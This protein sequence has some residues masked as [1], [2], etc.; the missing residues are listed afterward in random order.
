MK[1]LIII[2]LI[3]LYIPVSILVA[4]ED[5]V[6]CLY[7][8]EGIE[9]GEL[10]IDWGFSALVYYNDLL[11]LFDAGASAEILEHN[12][13]ILGVNLDAVDIAVLSHNHRDHITGFNY[14]L[15]VN[16]DVKIYLP[17]DRDLGGESSI[18]EEEWNSK[19]RVGYRFK[20]AD[21]TFVKQN[22]LIAPGVAL[23]PTVASSIGVYLKDPKDEQKTRYWGLPE[24]SLAIKSDDDKWILIDG[25]SH[26]GVAEIVNVCVLRSYLLNTFVF[27]V[28]EIFQLH[29]VT[30]SVACPCDVF[31]R[32]SL[33]WAS[34]ACRPHGA[35]ILRLYESSLPR[36][37]VRFLKSSGSQRTRYA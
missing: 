36:H 33:R 26:N 31:S 8:N 6:L 5:K 9:D 27:S 16:P 3:I 29:S 30:L 34:G 4:K 37:T 25:C 2:F 15:E 28:L 20:D 1:N 21:V 18:E 22:M 32:T 19:Y 17:D 10:I 14:L 7:N 35:S 12:C 11:I 23:I 24:V 13:D